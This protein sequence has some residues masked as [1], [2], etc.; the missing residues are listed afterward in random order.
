[1]N[2]NQ[3]GTI[4]EKVVSI[5]RESLYLPNARITA[6]TNLVEDLRLDSL[7]LITTVIDLEAMFGLELPDDAMA[8]FRTVGEIAQYLRRCMNVGETAVFP[9]CSVPG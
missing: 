3:N 8:R 9:P 6:E 2:S 7:D 1:M 5:I 4:L